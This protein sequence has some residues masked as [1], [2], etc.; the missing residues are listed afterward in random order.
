MEQRDSQDNFD[1]PLAAGDHRPDN[2]IQPDQAADKHGNK[3]VGSGYS[4]AVP[5]RKG[6]CIPFCQA[7]VASPVT[8]VVV[9]VCIAGSVGCLILDSP[10]ARLQ[11]QVKQLLELVDLVVVRQHS[12]VSISG[13]GFR[14]LI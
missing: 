5:T 2:D 10:L 7:V 4:E 11:P 6:G 9:L 1:N 14:P 13:I 12:F 8:E 3:S